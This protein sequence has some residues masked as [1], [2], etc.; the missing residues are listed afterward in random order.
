[1]TNNIRITLL[2]LEE[3]TKYKDIIPLINDDWWWLKDDLFESDRA[4]LCISDF[5]VLCNDCV[6]DNGVRPVLKTN[7]SNLNSLNPGNHIRIGSK[8]FTILSWDEFELVALCDELIATRQFDPDN[9]EWETSEL[10]QWL[11][12]E[13][14]KLIF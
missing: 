4:V 2:S 6:Y 9:N 3:Y 5:G 13:G 7:L 1:M 10:K 11:E 8:S 14:L 12:T